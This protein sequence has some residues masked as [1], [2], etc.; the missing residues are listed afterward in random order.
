MNNRKVVNPELSFKGS[1][2]VPIANLDEQEFIFRPR[3]R[4]ISWKYGK[5]KLRYVCFSRDGSGNHRR[6]QLEDAIR[7]DGEANRGYIKDDIALAQGILN[8]ALAQAAALERA[9]PTGALMPATCR[10]DS[11][12]L[13]T[14][15]SGTP[16]RPAG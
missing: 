4:I 15:A 2:Q 11:S 1:Y 8:W 13:P 5:P 16:R 7:R 9:G 3:R 12:V 14:R 6:K 10:G